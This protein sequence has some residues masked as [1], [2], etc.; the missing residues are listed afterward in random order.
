MASP[1]ATELKAQLKTLLTPIIGTSGTAK[2]KLF[3]YMALGFKSGEQE[4]TAI[5]RSSLDPATT[6]GGAAINRVNCLMISEESFTQGP[7][8]RDP[9][10]MIATPAGKNV[11]TRVLRLTY[12]YQ[13]GATSEVTFSANVELI[14]KA[15]NAAPKL[16]LDPLEQGKFIE[17]HSGLQMRSMA[18]DA[19]GSTLVH[20]GDGILTVKVIEPLG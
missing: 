14:R 4:D 6:T 9:T 2:A 11:V 13:F 18:P 3:D 8:Q 17:S 12:F 1:T 20:V 10:R 5:L 15:L 16:G 19:F 7:A